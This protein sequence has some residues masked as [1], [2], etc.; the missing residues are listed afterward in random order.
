MNKTHKT[1]VLIKLGGSIITNKEIPMSVRHQVLKRLVTE[2]SQARRENPHKLFVVGHGSGSFGH[3]PASQYDTLHGFKDEESVMGMAIVLDSA[4][5]LN[6]IVIKEFLEAGIP[7]VSLAPSNC[8]VTRK[9]VAETYFTE[10]FEEYI[11]NGLLPVTFGDVL[12]DRDQGCTIWSTEEVLSFFARKFQEKGWQVEQIVHVTETDGVYDLE[13][14]V[15]P[16]VTQM[17]WPEVQKAI[18]MTK[19]FDVT[20]GM[21]LKILE[22]LQLAEQ[23]IESKIVSGLRADNLYNALAARTFIGTTIQ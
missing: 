20:G 9:R 12:V 1:V 11:K 14:K 8:L 6:R 10:V 18:T 4:A 5:Q 23:K 3:V 22:S 21:G 7:A 2:I 13:K 17:N 16:V 19:G 15:L